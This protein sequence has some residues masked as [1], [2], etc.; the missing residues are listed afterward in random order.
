MLCGPATAKPE[1]GQPNVSLQSGSVSKS[2]SSTK[3]SSGQHS[4][5]AGLGVVSGMISEIAK[6]SG[7]ILNMGGLPQ[8]DHSP[9]I[10]S[11]IPATN[12]SAD[13]I[14]AYAALSGNPESSMTLGGG[15]GS[16]AVDPQS[17]V[18]HT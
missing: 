15:V 7:S 11:N 13:F 16:G 18:S 3:V 17:T 9:S 4:M 2:L 5:D 10:H 1:F 12:L 14:N 8:A 6:P